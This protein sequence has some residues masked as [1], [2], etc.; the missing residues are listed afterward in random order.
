MNDVS[1]PLGIFAAVHIRPDGT[2][3][4][5]GRDEVLS[6]NPEDGLLWVHLDRRST[7]VQTWLRDHSGIDEIDVEALLSEETRPRAYRP[8]HQASL[9]VI[10]RGVNN[11]PG[12]DPEDMVTIR[13]WVEKHR[14]LSFSSRPLAPVDDVLGM[15]NTEYAPANAAELLAAIA[16]AM[17]ARM[18]PAIDALR[19][20]LDALEEKEEEGIAVDV[21]ALLQI[22]RLGATLRRFLGP[23]KDVFMTVNTLHLP[24]IDIASEEEWRESTNT[25]FRYIEELEAIRERVGIL[26]DGINARIVARTNRTFHTVSVVAAFFVPF[27]FVTGLMGMNVGGIPFGTHPLGFWHVVGGLSI[28]ALV[29]LLIFRR[30]KWL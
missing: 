13:I 17:V 16:T 25:T 26:Q 11:L 10:L 30:M 1:P 21:A 3:R 2:H 18:E 12:A 28:W 27:T 7:V 20:A 14:V 6:F 22:R 15:L 5:V 4:H 8:R 29:Q 23:Q 19:D 9:L 24:W